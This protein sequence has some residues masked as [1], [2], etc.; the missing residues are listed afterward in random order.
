[1]A[2]LFRYLVL[3]LAIGLY[4]GGCSRSVL[5]FFYQ[6][7]IAADDYR[8]GD[9]YRLAN[10]PQFKEVQPPC[11]S[12]PSLTHQPDLSFYILGDSFSE[13]ER[14]GPSD[15]P[16]S[17]Y[18]RTKWENQRRIQL[19][20]THRNVLLIESVERHVREHFARP[21]DNLVV[22]ADTTRKPVE[23]SLSMGNRIR[24]LLS[25]I[26]P[27]AVVEERLETVLFSHNFFLWWKEQKAAFDQRVF[28]R[29]SPKVGLS[30]NQQHLFV[31]LDTDTTTGITSSFSP[32]PNPDLNRLVDS[33][34]IT[35]D[36]FRSLGF[37]EVYLSII[38]NKATIADPAY[39]RYNHLIERVQQH[40]AL[41]MPVVNVYARYK[42]ARQPL[43]ALS[44]SHWNCQGRALW[45]EAV[46][47]RLR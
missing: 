2:R 24:Q 7:G 9:L 42:A 22:V 15:F 21:V 23:P 11:A 35:Y 18:Q 30:R 37:D 44:D 4:A 1:M 14:I 27:T 31:G 3:L 34:N 26:Q 39:G 28:S 41:H 6:T 29:I 13:P 47:E 5:Q 10:L 45:L 16:A 36:R 17:F 12:L 40:P 19:D 20:T 8:Y 43:Y 32:L 38:P 25:L 33:L 46:N